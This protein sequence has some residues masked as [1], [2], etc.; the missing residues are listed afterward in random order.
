M[1]SLEQRIKVLSFNLREYVGGLRNASEEQVKQSI[2]FPFLSLLGFNINN[3]YEVSFEEKIHSGK[4]DCLIKIKD[5]I[6]LIECKKYGWRLDSRVTQQL[7]LYFNSYRA[8]N[9]IGI[10]TNGDEFKFFAEVDDTGQM[11][12]E[13]YYIFRLS[14]PT[15][16]DYD[17]LAKYTKQHI[18][19]TNPK[20]DKAYGRFERVCKEF[21]EELSC[22][23]ISTELMHCLK[24]E[25]SINKRE[26]EELLDNDKLNEIAQRQLKEVFGIENS[27]SYESDTSGFIGDMSGFGGMSSFGDTSD[28]GGLTPTD[29]SYEFQ[30]SNIDEP[31]EHYFKDYPFKT[32]NG[33]KFRYFKFKGALLANYSMRQLLLHIIESSLCAMPQA[34]QE[35]LDTFESGTYRI[36]PEKMQGEREKEYSYISS[37]NISVKTKLGAEN[38]FR[39]I[40]KILDM[41]NIG[42]DELIIS[43]EDKGY[44]KRKKQE[45]GQ[46]KQREQKQKQ[47]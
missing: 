35:L 32:Y 45:R 33:C 17:E 39:F 12:L 44:N 29:F 9:K 47:E 18:L 26:L 30:T 6:I 19:E 21:F 23:N 24:T 34:K 15:D 4:S 16:E 25:S 2:I 31:E 5:T 7:A 40:Q 1:D 22:G 8:E 28:F 3:P 46:E 38:I 27:E 20:Q 41:F 10:T 37:Q 43:I 14:S 13:P 36:I 42:Y 11:E